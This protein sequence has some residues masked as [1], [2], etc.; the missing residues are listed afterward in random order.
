MRPFDPCAEI[1]ATPANS[2][3]S[4]SIAI[5]SI[6]VT[7]VRAPA[8][9]TLSPVEEMEK[10]P[11]ALPIEVFPSPVPRL[12]SPLPFTVKLPDP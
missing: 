1:E 4:E 8:V 10:S 3:E 2:S 6:E 12:T 7:P 11:V 9:V 5:V